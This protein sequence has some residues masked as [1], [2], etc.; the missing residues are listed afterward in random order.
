MTTASPSAS[1]IEQPTPEQ[2]ERAERTQG[3][4]GRFLFPAIAVALAVWGV[5]IAMGEKVAVTPF[6]PTAEFDLGTHEGRHVIGGDWI[7]GSI[8]G[9]DIDLGINKGVVYLGIATL[10]CIIMA[11]YVHVKVRHRLHSESRAQTVVE[12]LYEFAYDQ[13]AS[14][15]GTKMFNRYMPYVASIFFF[16]LFLNLTSFVPLP[17]NTHHTIGGLDYFYS[18]SLYAVTSNIYCTVTLA[19]LTF[20]VYHY[21]GVRAH[22]F[23]GY[24]KTWAGGQKGPIAI[25]IFFIEVLTNLLLKPL[26]L[27]LRLFANML[28]GHILILLMLGLAGILAGGLLPTLI[29]QVGGGLLALA[30]YLFEMVLIAALQAFIFAILS[31]IYIGSAAEEHH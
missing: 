10:A 19:L 12:S 15:L 9:Q 3:L 26:S 4:V 27:A 16:I 22:G 23:V 8:F 28:S 6:D 18:F 11:M 2:P 14:S 17:L 29:A 1:S 30:F 31:A 5:V 24:L 20:F 21:E 13:I 7:V 25:L